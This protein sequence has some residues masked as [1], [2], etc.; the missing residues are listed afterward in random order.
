MLWGDARQDLS[1]LALTP[2]C[3]WAQWECCACSD[4]CQVVIACC[5]WIRG[6]QICGWAPTL[7]AVCS[8]LYLPLAACAGR[9]TCISHHIQM[10]ICQVLLCSLP[11]FFY[12]YTEDFSSSPIKLCHFGVSFIPAA[13]FSLCSL[14]CG[15]RSGRSATEL[16]LSLLRPG[17]RGGVIEQA[18]LTSYSSA[19]AI[20]LVCVCSA[21]SRRNYH[22]FSEMC[23]IASLHVL[24][25]FPLTGCK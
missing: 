20:K 19:I 7:V 10:F 22:D 3:S 2:L 25:G 16:S 23:L 13:S 17:V 9:D 5:Y 1:S 4:C 11:L 18:T 21:F 12:N 8:L 14:H 15:W 6:S 24:W